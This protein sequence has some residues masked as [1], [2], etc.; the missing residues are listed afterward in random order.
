MKQ[1]MEC[2]LESRVG[3][4]TVLTS[5]IYRAFTQGKVLVA[6]CIDLAAA[7]DNV[8]VEELEHDMRGCNVELKFVNTIL[9]MRCEEGR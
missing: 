6:V 8:E 1:R 7:Y 9:Q 3:N 4:L 2:S 5:D